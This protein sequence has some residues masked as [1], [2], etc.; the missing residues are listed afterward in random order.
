MG[1][2][3]SG[4]LSRNINQAYN[5]KKRQNK[6]EPTTDPY[7]ALFLACKEDA[8]SQDTAFIREVYSA[9]ESIVVLAT[10]EQVKNITKFCTNE[11]RFSVFE[12]DRLLI[13]GNL[14]LLQCN[15]NIFYYFTG[16]AVNT[17]H[18]GTNAYTSREDKRSLQTFT[19]IHFQTG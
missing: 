1:V 3:S 7:N 14:V 18:G 11:A 6:I 9:P 12:A 2:I 8:K 15:T 4:C 19:N 17:C 16:G 10:N 13:S 5:L